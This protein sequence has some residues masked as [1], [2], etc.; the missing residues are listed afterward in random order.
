MTLRSIARVVLPTPVKTAIRQ[1]YRQAAAAFTTAKARLGVFDP[2]EEYSEDY[3]AKRRNDP[4]RADAHNVATALDEVFG[5]DSIIDFGCAIGAYLEP[6]HEAGI[7]IRGVEYVEH[8]FE[9]AV[10]PEEDLK[11][12]DLTQ[13]Y[14]HERKYDIALSI[15]VAE[16]LPPDAAETFVDTLTNASDTVVLTAAPPGQ[17][18]V[19]HFNERPREYWIGLFNER[20]YSYDPEAVER[21]RESITVEKATW[22]P[23]NLFVFRRD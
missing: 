23:P 21:L 8:A 6:F 3:Y 16:H 11:R 13:P 15:E 2:N 22:I 9:H 18:G 7:D 12:H 19:H 10:V 20:G 14:D 5:P 1:S 4:W 17:G